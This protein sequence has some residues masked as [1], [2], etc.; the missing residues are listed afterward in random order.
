[1]KE[2][3][4]IVVDKLNNIEGVDNQDI[5]NCNNSYNSNQGNSSITLDKDTASEKTSSSTLN[6][7]SSTAVDSM[8]YIDPRA[9]YSQSRKKLILFT[10]AFAGLIGPIGS[11]I[12][13]SCIGY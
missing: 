6:S 4:D 1:M 2:N 5:I 11:T 3:T 12:Y 7:P 13:V 10:I 8:V 9:K